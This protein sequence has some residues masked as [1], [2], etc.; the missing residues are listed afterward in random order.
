MNGKMDDVYIYGSALSGDQVKALYQEG[1]AASAG[2]Q[3]A[4]NA[5]LTVATG[6]IVDLNGHTQTIGGLSGSG[7]VSNGTL[8]VAGTTA[9][10]GTN[11]I[12]MLTLATT[13]TLSGTL[14]I[15]VATGGACDVLQVQGPLN[16]VNLD[17][18]IQ[19]MGQLN[20][21]KEYVIA[22]FTPGGLTGRFQSN[23]LD[24]LKIIAYNNATGEIR[25]VGRGTIISFQ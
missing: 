25:L 24:G 17:L 19:D 23:N 22:R 13:T 20:I 1:T 11:V 2:N 12:G 3:L 10:G 21:G 7:V 14:L 18:M 5:N 15:D 9:P 6:A 8:T 4:T 16:L